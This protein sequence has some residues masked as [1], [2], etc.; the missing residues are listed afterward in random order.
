MK[1]RLIVHTTNTWKREIRKSEIIYLF[2]E[3]FS[4]YS[5]SACRCYA[6]SGYCRLDKFFFNINKFFVKSV[7]FVSED[8]V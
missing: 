4:E 1:F 8:F 5:D 7:N 3:Y 2:W 6:W